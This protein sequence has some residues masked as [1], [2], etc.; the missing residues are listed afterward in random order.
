MKR[1]II[2][3]AGSIGRGFIGQIF[4]SSDLEIIFIDI[5]KEIVNEINLRNQYPLYIIYNDQTE[6]VIIQTKQNMEKIK[7]LEDSGA[8]A[9]V[10][11]SLFEEQIQLESVKLEEELSKFKD[12][13][14]EMTSIFPDLKHAGPQEH[15]MWVRKAKES[16]DIP[17]FASLNAVSQENWVDYAQQLA[18]TGVDGLE[19]NF[20]AVP[21]DF[22]RSVATLA[23]CNTT[24]PSSATAKPHTSD[25]D[26]A[27]RIDASTGTCITS[28]G[29]DAPARLPPVFGSLFIRSTT[30]SSA[31]RSRAQNN[32]PSTSAICLSDSGKY[33]RP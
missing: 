29:A 9:I 15:L 33:T 23:W 25:S 30:P 24:T 1:A 10:I 7:Q 6:K 11:K 16:V 26:P 21:A 27:H 12:L 8:G 4:F 3:G 32:R 5:D 20:Y 13:T 2:F 18:Q 22:T 31:A 28:R 17:V 19:L 14:A